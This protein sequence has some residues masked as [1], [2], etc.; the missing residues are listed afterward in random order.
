MVD[1]FSLKNVCI[2]SW[3]LTIPIVMIFST[4][5]IVKSLE[6]INNIQVKKKV[7]G[8]SITRLF[9]CP[10]TFALSY[11]YNSSISVSGESWKLY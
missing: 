11:I 7:I 6:H 3:P 4:V 1:T 10:V 2:Y 9:Y 8:Q 5:H